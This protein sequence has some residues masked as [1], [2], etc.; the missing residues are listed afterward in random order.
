MHQPHTLNTVAKS[1]DMAT[2]LMAQSQIPPNPINFAVW[3][4]YTSGE[5]PNLSQELQDLIDRKVEFTSALNESIC[6]KYFGFKSEG[7][8]ITRAGDKLES[9]LQ[10]IYGEL[11]QAEDHAKGNCDRVATLIENVRTA[12]SQA[13]VSEIVGQ[14]VSETRYIIEKNRRLEHQLEASSEEIGELR[15]DLI[16]M[17]QAA[18]H[19]PL[20]GILNRKYFDIKLTEETALAMTTGQD[21]CLIMPDIDNFKQSY[22][23]FGH[24]VG[25]EVLKVT[26]RVLTNGIKGR[27]TAARFGG[28]EFCVILPR[29]GLANAVTVAEG[30]RETLANK[31]LKARNKGKTFGTITLSLGVAQNIDG[32]PLTDLIERAY[33]A[34]YDAKRDG[35]NRTVTARS[36]VRG[37]V[38]S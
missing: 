8:A 20:T 19:D 34:L 13:T 10:Q 15:D 16:S 18:M 5:H 7:A 24:Q 33:T 25:D 6:E 14:L 30:I 4:G 17:R 2:Q 9:G 11:S 38:A 26:S 36:L 37:G 32:E 12:A 3:Y 23:T 1:H 29:T 31:E 35:R 28:E 22:D 27:D 21:L